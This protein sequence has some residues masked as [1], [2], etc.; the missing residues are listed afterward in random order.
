[1]SG[2]DE[3]VDRGAD[4]L[5]QL[6][7]AGTRAG[8]AKAK[9]ARLFADD[10]EFLRKLKPSLIA[11]RAKG[12]APTDGVPTEV[13]PPEPSPQ[14]RAKPAKPSTRRSGG[15]PSPFVVLGAALAAG[16]ILAHVVDWLGH[17]YPRD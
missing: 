4:R 7:V 9:V 12:E 6:V 5:Q 16:M 13:R 10:P 17:R 11:A 8:G 3:K 2:V 14:P 15:G 1:M